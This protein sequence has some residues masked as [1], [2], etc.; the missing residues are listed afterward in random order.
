MSLLRNFSLEIG[1]GINNKIRE[2]ES[3][4]NTRTRSGDHR[5]HF[6]TT[7]QR[8]AARRVKAVRG[9]NCFTEPDCH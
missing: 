9:Q 1:A 2:T 5:L 7:V 4:L 8:P 6:M 3:H